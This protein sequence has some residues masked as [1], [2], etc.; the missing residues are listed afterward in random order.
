MC[1]TPQ[2]STRISAGS[3]SPATRIVSSASV[4][5][6]RHGMADTSKAKATAWRLF[7]NLSQQDVPSLECAQIAGSAASVS[8]TRGALLHR[9]HFRLL[10]ELKQHTRHSLGL[11]LLH[12]VTC[13]LYEVRTQ[14]VR[15]R[16][17]PHCFEVA[18]G[19]V[20]APVF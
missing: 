18:R 6:A 12:P 10:H 1:G 16:S 8:V 14:H 2:R 15:A 11:L 4:S 5:R 17:R 7:M 13:V 19:L 9:H 20:G 3:C